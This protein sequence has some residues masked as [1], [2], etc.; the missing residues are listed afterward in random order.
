MWWR[1]KAVSHRAIIQAGAESR[2]Q[3]CVDAREPE[4]IE[5]NDRC[6]CKAGDGREKRRSV[7]LCLVAVKNSSHSPAFV[8]HTY[9]E[10]AISSPVASLLVGYGCI[11]RASTSGTSSPPSEKYKL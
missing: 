6:S 1:V 11:P 4:C 2:V 8:R 9:T 7:L 10:T 5:L 3:N